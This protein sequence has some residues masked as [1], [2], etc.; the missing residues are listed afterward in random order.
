MGSACR[1]LELRAC[2]ELAAGRSD[3]ALPDVK[4]ILYL[5]DSLKGEPTL[6]S[7][8]VRMAAVKVAIQPVWEGLA[9]HAWTHAK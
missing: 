7:A 6:I 4:L 8:L 3:A 9:E 1:R 2:A 5:A